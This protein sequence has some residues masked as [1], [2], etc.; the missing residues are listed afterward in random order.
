MVRTDRD[1]RVEKKGAVNSGR[2]NIVSGRTRDAMT[3]AMLMAGYGQQATRRTVLTEGAIFPK[4]KLLHDRNG[5]SIK[6]DHWLCAVG[7]IVM[8]TDAEF[9]MYRAN[10]VVLVD[11]EPE[12]GLP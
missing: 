1:R 3:S 8:L 12:G 11:A 9:E 7:D 5:N 4:A 10:G 6:G 2:R